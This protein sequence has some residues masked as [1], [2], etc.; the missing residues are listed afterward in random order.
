M[1][2]MHLSLIQETRGTSFAEPA[3]S[4]LPILG[5]YL[6]EDY[7]HELS[8]GYSGDSSANP[9]SE[10]Q[11][12][13]RMPFPTAQA[14]LPISRMPQ[15]A[16]PS[17]N[18][19]R[20]LRVHDGYMPARDWLLEGG[21]ISGIGGGMATVTLN[22]KDPLAWVRKYPTRNGTDGKDLV[23]TRTQLLQYLTASL[24]DTVPADGENFKKLPIKA[25]DPAWKPT[26]VQATA[27]YVSGSLVDTGEIITIPAPD[28]LSI[29]DSLYSVMAGWSSGLGTYGLTVVQE[30][31][32]MGNPGWRW[33]LWK[34]V[35]VPKV[36]TWELMNLSSIEFSNEFTD[37][38]VYDDNNRLE[39]RYLG[40]ATIANPN[41]NGA[42]LGV[43]FQSYSKAD[44]NGTLP[45]PTSRPSTGF[46][47]GGFGGGGF[48][49]GS[50][51]GG[52]GGSLGGNGSTGAIGSGANLGGSWAAPGVGGNSIFPVQGGGYLSPGGTAVPVP[53]DGRNLLLLI[54]AFP[55]SATP[56][57]VQIPTSAVMPGGDTTPAHVWRISVDGVFSKTVTVAATAT[58]IIQDVP[59][60]N[61]EHVI[62]IVPGDLSY[63]PGW[64]CRFGNGIATASNAFIKQVL[65]MGPGCYISPSGKPMSEQYRFIGFS[66]LVSVSDPISKIAAPSSGI[67]TNYHKLKFV[68]CPKLEVAPEDAIDVSKLEGALPDGWREQEFTAC[69]KLNRIPKLQEMPGITSIGNGALRL[70]CRRSADV[71]FGKIP[72]FENVTTVGN[73]FMLA[74]G[75][76][77]KEISLDPS[78]RNILPKAHTVGDNFMRSL[79]GYNY[80]GNASDPDVGVLPTYKAKIDRAYMPLLPSLK[81]IG[82]NFLERTWSYGQ[83]ANGTEIVID[84]MPAWPIESMPIATF[85]MLGIFSS[86][87][88]ILETMQ[89]TQLPNLPANLAAAWH[90]ATYEDAKSLKFFNPEVFV[91]KTIPT[92]AELFSYAGTTVPARITNGYRA[93]QYKGATAPVGDV[94]KHYFMET[95]SR[96]IPGKDPN[97]VPL[98]GGAS[99]FRGLG[100]AFNGFDG[101]TKRMGYVDGT[102]AVENENGLAIS[103]FLSFNGRKTSGGFYNGGDPF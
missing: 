75:W 58:S 94:A 12:S 57:P 78:I 90:V 79:S 27:G 63:S 13:F 20:Y 45:M 81:T 4:S 99:G 34:N 14:I 80:T 83:P 18:R 43:D 46:Q 65:A 87:T 92:A 61:Q 22:L 49:G 73:D 89:E 33:V 66:E 17:E 72:T 47:G 101:S 62:E 55:A 50:G 76:G 36:L 85:A 48:G 24:S 51:F 69:P 53:I 31:D 41:L 10:A 39:H 7:T 54:K 35:V 16:L 40:G 77:L 56:T 9:I 11:A 42:W 19:A 84:D 71:R 97:V 5:Q 26:A 74:I 30:L 103:V 25:F 98:P 28:P 15:I 29:E 52:G 67:G 93:R 86:T 95:V 38:M 44:P 96:D 32:A 2:I 102:D 70:W 100:F 59:A 64:A 88:G 6:A 82:R 37:S 23:G 60:D 21:E 8:F 1:P 68:N 3:T 91:S